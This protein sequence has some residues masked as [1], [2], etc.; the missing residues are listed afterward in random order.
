MRRR[1]SS[2]RI[3]PA[4]TRLCSSDS[5]VSAGTCIR[6]PFGSAQIL[7]YPHR[8]RFGKAQG[9]GAVPNKLEQD[10]RG[11]ASLRRKGK[12]GAAGGRADLDQEEI[13]WLLSLRNLPRRR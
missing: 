10:A 2:S 1:A 8:S 9:G 13:S 6:P 4:I 3:M 7:T 11:R 5:L 12:P